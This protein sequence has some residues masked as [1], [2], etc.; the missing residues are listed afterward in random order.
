MFQPKYQKEGKLLI[1]GVNR[2]LHYRR[3]LLEE[4]T[5]QE[6]EKRRD[7]FQAA[8]KAKDKEKSEEL[9][10]DLTKACE[11]AAPNYRNSSI[12]ENIEVIFVAI[13]IALGIRAYI[14]QPF[15]IPTGSMQPT[16]NGIIVHSDPNMKVPNPVVRIFDTAIR[17]KVWEN[18]VADRD[19]VIRKEVYDSERRGY[20][21]HGINDSTKLK[22]FTFTNVK[23]EEGSTYRLFGPENKTAKAF[24][25]YEGMQL[26]KG[27]VI[28]RGYTDMGDHVIVDKFSYHF[29]PPRRG[30]VFVFT[31]TGIKG[32][33]E[34][35][36]F[37]PAW[38]SQH[39]IKRLSGV[40]GDQLSITPDGVLMVNGE[41]SKSHGHK[42]VASKENGYRGYQPTKLCLF[43]ITVQYHEN[44]ITSLSHP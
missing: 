20:V 41:P 11:G 2:F 18:E 32:I 15:K 40:P 25:L 10:K 35:G 8:L 36:R 34:G 23:T 1:K 16:L 29:F 44:Y 22:F 17:G 7:A 19:E 37:N 4:K 31:T 43:L 39:Y 14:A 28:A 13:A 38:G 3:D 24:G 42:L 27:D 33:E 9:A 12:A 21:N 6:I 26:K 5:I 30:E